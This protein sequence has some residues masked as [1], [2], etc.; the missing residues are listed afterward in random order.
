[1]HFPN[2]K[3]KPEFCDSGFF[4]SGKGYQ[5]KP[6]YFFLTFVSTF[7]ISVA[8]KLTTAP[9]TAKTTVFKISSECKLGTI[10]SN[11][12]A[13]VPV[14]SEMLASTARIVFGFRQILGRIVNSNLA[15]C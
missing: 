6:D 14:L 9:I 1:M 4:K 13:A 2:K 12:P 5:S 8:V 15:H 10:L 11:V 3:Y 7:K